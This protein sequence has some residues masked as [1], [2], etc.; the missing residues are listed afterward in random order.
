MKKI[1]YAVIPFYVMTVM[2]AGAQTQTQA[3]ARI[4]ITAGDTAIYAVMY[5]NETAREFVSLLPLTL[6]AFDRIGLVKSTVLPRPISDK[7]GRT[8]RY[9]RG[10]VFYWP[11]GPEV[12]FCYS[13][14]LPQTVVPIIHIGM[15]ESGVE[16]FQKYTG[17]I[18]VEP[19]D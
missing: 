19:V 18:I 9:A 6:T 12:A 14:H 8:R 16:V 7:G 5:D 4:K 15:I 17:K 1:I 2:T 13:D 3:G 11:E 10:A